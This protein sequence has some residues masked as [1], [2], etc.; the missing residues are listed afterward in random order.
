MKKRSRSLP[1]VD[2][3]I[4]TQLPVWPEAFRNELKQNSQNAFEYFAIMSAADRLAADARASRITDA[5]FQTRSQALSDRMAKFD[6]TSGMTLFS[7]EISVYQ[8]CDRKDRG[9]RAHLR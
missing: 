9:D 5:E 2:Q 7:G 3:Q 6:Q 1:F 8:H 4:D